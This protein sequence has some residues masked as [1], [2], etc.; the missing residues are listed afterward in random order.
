MGAC[1]GTIEGVSLH[2]IYLTGTTTTGAPSNIGLKL[3]GPDGSVQLTAEGAVRLAFR[4]L[5]LR[6]RG[7]A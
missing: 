4:L 6:L 3:S 1:L 2:R 7:W 5:K